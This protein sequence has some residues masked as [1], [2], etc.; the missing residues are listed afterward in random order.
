MTRP[1]FADFVLY[2]L[3]L[4]CLSFGGPA[5]QIAMMQADL[6]EGRAW[7][8][9]TRF[10]HMLN[11]CML[12]PGPEAQQLATYM[13][14]RL[15][16]VGG[17][18]IAGGLF[19]L[20]GAV[21]MLALSWLAASH[22]DTA[23]VMAVF[24]S[25][26]PAVVAVIAAAVWR[27]GRRTFH[28]PASVA[29]AVAAFA[30]LAGFGVPFPLVVAAAAGLGLAAAGTGWFPLPR[31]AEAEETAQA[32]PIRPARL[33]AA[34]AAAW[35]FPLLAI[36]AIFGPEPWMGLT[37]LMTKAAFVTFGGAY[38]V[39]PYVAG[40]A[41]DTYGW[42]SPADMVNGLALAESTPGPLI[43][44]LEYVGFFAGWHTPGTLPPEWA[45]TLGAGLA[46]YVT[47]LP[48]FLLIFAGAPVA[49][50]LIH[51]R[52]AGCALA[53]VGAA[54]VGVMANLGVYLGRTVLLPGGHAD[55]LAIAVALLSLVVLLKSRLAVHW[56]VAATAAFGALRAVTGLA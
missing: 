47:F 36:R 21:V 9:A 38:A 5:G 8:D 31:P 56:V 23:L 54:V 26:K 27:V 20:P 22:G 50:R 48:S 39:L 6:V 2:W 35:L 3:R 25:V 10:I 42:L 24:D 32:L 40:Q 43:L 29:L 44:V 33:I 28:G 19:V 4:G 49:E 53:A 46:V 15:F 18:L 30:A 45:G 16:G 14:W 12:L 13:G 11:V 7:I 34:F 51:S 37:L 41:V 52:R 55:P 1:R 17:G